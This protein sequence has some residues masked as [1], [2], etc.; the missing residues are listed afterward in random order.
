[1]VLIL[2]TGGTIDKVYHDA[3]SEYA[4]GEPQAAF[5]LREAGVTAPFQVRTL[6]QKDSLEM[7]DADRELVAAHVRLAE[8]AR[9]LITHGTDTMADTARAVSPA[10]S[11][12][13]K[14]VIL[15]GSL[16]PALHR[17]TDAD[18]NLGFAFAAVQTLPPGVYVAMNGQVFDAARVRKNREAN[19]FEQTA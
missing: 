12:G 15:V 3:R 1:M 18:F 16:S 9:I 14:T 4:V 10:A 11:E 5:I 2:T 6:M 7:S 13:G 8:E 17:A 19:R